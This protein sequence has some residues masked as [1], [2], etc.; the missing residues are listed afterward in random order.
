S[1]VEQSLSAEQ[2]FTADASHELRSPLSAIQMRLQVLKRK[3]QS[4]ATLAQDLIQIEK[5]I[6]RGTQV[7]EKLLLLARLDPEK[8]QHLPQQNIDLA[9]MIQ[10]VLKSLMPFFQEKQLKLE[11]SLNHAET[12][13]NP[14]LIFSC[15]RNLIDNAIKYTPSSGSIVIRS[16]QQAGQ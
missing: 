12:V 5:D 7:L 3:Y 16:E 10:D 1:R 2:R 11:F 15:L 6:N 9:D 13:G 4:Y 8:T 14:E